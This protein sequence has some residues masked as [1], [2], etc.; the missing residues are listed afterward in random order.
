MAVT[1]PI[2]CRLSLS[3]GLMWAT[4]YRDIYLR[5]TLR[6]HCITSSNTIAGLE[7]YIQLG[8]IDLCG[9]EVI[10]HFGGAVWPPYNSLYVERRFPV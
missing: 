2:H 9:P 8:Q 4:A 1:Y 6:T 5:R 10:F 3:G 7:F